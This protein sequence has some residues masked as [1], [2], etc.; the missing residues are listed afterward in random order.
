MSITAGW[1]EIANEARQIRRLLDLT[2]AEREA[3]FVESNQRALE[4]L[5]DAHRSP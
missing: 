1:P 4:F 5:A 2:D 3:H